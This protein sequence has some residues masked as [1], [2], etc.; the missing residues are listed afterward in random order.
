MAQEEVM[1]GIRRDQTEYESMQDM[2]GQSIYFT[3][4]LAGSSIPVKV[5]AQWK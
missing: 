2:L 5:N 4:L 3:V 1:D